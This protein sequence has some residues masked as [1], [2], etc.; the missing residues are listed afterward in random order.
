MMA[1]RYASV[2]LAVLLGLVPGVLAVIYPDY[3]GG[4]FYA[5]LGIT[6]T[7]YA[8]IFGVIAAVLYEDQ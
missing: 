4:A 7:I 1:L 2:V 8:C 6:A 5:A 3:Q